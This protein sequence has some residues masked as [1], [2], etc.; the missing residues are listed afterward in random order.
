[1]N[2]STIAA[3]RYAVHQL[4]GVKNDAVIEQVLAE[5]SN[6]FVDDP[7]QS[8]YEDSPLP[9]TPEVRSLTDQVTGIMH[10]IDPRLEPSPFWAHILQP[11]ESTMYHTHSAGNFPGH[12]HSWVYYPLVPPR[13]GDLVF[14]CQLND[15]RVFHGIEPTVGRLVV[16]PAGMPHM[17]E[18][19]AGEGV[20]ISV[21]G[22]FF[23]SLQTTMDVISG[24]TTSR[25]SEFCG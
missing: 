12:G 23:L 9:D 3:A 22:N 14:I 18:R 1:V 15:D 25:V 20:R 10:A 13:S 4:I 8:T 19:H 21:S 17:T 5:Q 16:F 2:L 11:G 24:Q 6:R 7:R